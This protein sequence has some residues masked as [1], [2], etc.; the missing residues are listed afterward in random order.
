MKKFLSLMMALALVLSLGVTAFAAE[1]G[2]ITITNATIDETYTV[3]KIFDASVK[4]AA[5][6]STGKG[7]AY[8]IEKDNQFFEALFGADGTA[9]NT[10]FIYN[11]NTGSVTEKEGVNDTELVTYLTELVQAGSYTPAVAPITATSDEV[12]F[13][14]LPY[15]YYMIISTLG[16]K[17]TINSNAPDVKVIDKNQEPAPDFNKQVQ[18][19]VDEHGDPL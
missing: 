3:Y 10:Y 13:E 11:P 1:T 18:I 6:G 17:V 15:G 8:S 16:K 5:D 14:S 9:N 4:P 12:K 19:G 2:S 7:V